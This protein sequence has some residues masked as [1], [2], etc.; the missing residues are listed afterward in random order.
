MCGIFAC[1][2]H[3]ENQ[4][5]LGE[6]LEGLRHLQYRGYDSWGYGIQYNGELL[7]YR[8]L[9]KIIQ[10]DETTH[11]TICPSYSWTNPDSPYITES[12]KSK[13]NVIIGHT[14]WSDSGSPSIKNAHPIVGGHGEVLVVHNGTITNTPDISNIIKHCLYTETDTEYLAHLAAQLFNEAKI[15]TKFLSPS[16]V[17]LKRLNEQLKGTFAYCLLAKNHSDTIYF[18]AR[19]SS[20]FI[21]QNGYISSDFQALPDGYYYQLQDDEYGFMRLVDGKIEIQVWYDGGMIK[22]IPW[23]QNCKISVPSRES[24][25]KHHML[26]EIEEQPDRIENFKLPTHR[27]QFNWNDP[28]ILFGCG[29]S[30]N[31]AM[32]ATKFDNKWTAKYASEFIEK[33]DLPCVAIS[34][35]GNTLDVVD[36]AKTQSDLTILTNNVQGE[37][38]KYATRIIDIHAGPELSVAATKSFTM[39]AWALYRLAD[40]FFTHKLPE[41]VGQVIK[42]KNLIKQT[43]EEIFFYKNALCLSH[44]LGYPIAREIALK[45]KEVSLIHAE[46]IPSSEVKHGPIALITPE[47]L[48]LFI[49]NDEHR[50]DRVC[51]N[52]QQIKA[53]GGKILTI[54]DKELLSHYSKIRQ[55]SDWLIETPN[56]GLALLQPLVN[57]VAGQLL[58][59]YLAVKKNCDVDR[60]DGLCKSITVF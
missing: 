35:S 44:G 42:G 2:R 16:P 30:Y 14:R 19:T 17:I 49:I 12:S 50:I 6:C 52:I 4:D 25:P 56:V 39:T 45:L 9:N 27:G 26:S 33:T 20:L 3:D 46:A 51:S 11:H 13:V 15:D 59:Y 18:S 53:R 29:S 21:H 7:A 55:L 31:A 58:A 36:V 5:L 57:N 1:I 41:L 22:T 37:L 23:F 38:S 43:V 47:L 54:V 40:N 34:Q 8:S 24:A 48:S 32:L 10:L 28:L 60:P